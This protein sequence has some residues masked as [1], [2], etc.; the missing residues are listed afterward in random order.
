MVSLDA[1][2]YY[3]CISRCVRRTFLCG[4]DSATG[5]DYEHRRGLIKERLLALGEAFA[6]DIASYSVMSNHYH[7]VL[8][9]DRDTAAEWTQEQVIAHWHALF[10]GSVLS[11]RY[12]QGEALSKAESQALIE[13][14]KSGGND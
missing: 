14:E 10:S 13:R 11:Q 3:H 7:L 4:F 8:F 1:T 6:I 5:K 9:I 2:P 12:T